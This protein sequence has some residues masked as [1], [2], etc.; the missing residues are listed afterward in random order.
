MNMQ[1]YYNI[2]YFARP[3]V[4]EEFFDAEP[5]YRAA[6]RT[7]QAAK[8]ALERSAEDRATAFSHEQRCRAA[9][10]EAVRIVLGDIPTESVFDPANLEQLTLLLEESKR[11]ASIG[12]AGPTAAS[13][14]KII[15]EFLEQERRYTDAQRLSLESHAACQDAAINLEQATNRQDLCADQLVATLDDLDLARPCIHTCELGAV[16]KQIQ[17]AM[18]NDTRLEIYRT[19]E[20]LEALSD[21]ARARIDELR[22]IGSTSGDTPCVY[23]RLQATVSYVPTDTV[24]VSVDVVRKASGEW[25][26]CKQVRGCAMCDTPCVIHQ[27]TLSHTQ[28]CSVS[29][30]DPAL[31]GT[32][33]GVL[34]LIH[35][36]SRRTYTRVSTA[37]SLS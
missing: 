16:R 13:R 36:V 32:P 12:E 15:E 28:P 23:V 25:F 19:L 2:G 37:L 8:E 1:Y 5:S 22:Y 21:R 30:R 7:A 34:L 9:A 4:V 27:L 3:E 20:A 35:I 17:T 31:A 26:F 29:C 24:S 14:Q 6:Q 10:V 18:E 11:V 33:D